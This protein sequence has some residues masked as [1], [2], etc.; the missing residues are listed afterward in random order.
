MY[1]SV[2]VEAEHNELILKN[3]NGDFV[4]IPANKRSWVKKKIEEDCHAC[5]DSLVEKLPIV[6]QYAEFGGL[7]PEEE[8]SFNMFNS[9]KPTTTPIQVRPPSFNMFNKTATQA[10]PLA[11]NAP[12]DIYDLKEIDA[13]AK[14]YVS[15][16]NYEDM[17]LKRG[18]SVDA[19]NKRRALVQGFDTSKNVEYTPGDASF[20]EGGKMTLGD[21]KGDWPSWSDVVSHEY[22]HIEISDTDSPLKQKDWEDFIFRN[23]LYNPNTIP[24]DLLVKSLMGDNSLKIDEAALHD[25]HPQESR[26]DLFQLRYQLKKTGIYDSSKGAEFKKE[27]L[28]KLKKAGEWNRLFRLYDD[29]DIVW[30]MNNIASNYLEDNDNSK[31]A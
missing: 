11:A 25:L 10:S 1:R 28:D 8:L 22:G 20:V 5:I 7:Y 9:L 19:I 24:Y 17:L 6:S 13:F 16:K 15:S 21:D 23:K 27:D 31:K 12:S 29:E 18:Y 4:I 14:E 2:K 3:S 30:F 26:S